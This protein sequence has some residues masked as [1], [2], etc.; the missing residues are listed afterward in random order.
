MEHL[1]LV[2]LLYDSMRRLQPGKWFNNNGRMQYPNKGK[3]TLI[4][5]R[6]NGCKKDWPTH[7]LAEHHKTTRRRCLEVST[8]MGKQPRF[9]LR[10]NMF[11]RQVNIYTFFTRLY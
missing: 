5:M 11:N 10:L 3:I 7:Y 2:T 4:R 9:C 1:T 8:T 6:Q